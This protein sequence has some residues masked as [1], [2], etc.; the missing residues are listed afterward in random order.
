[1]TKIC[2]KCGEEKSLEDF[3]KKTNAPDGRTSQCKTCVAKYAKTHREANPEKVKVRNAKWREENPEY[4]TKWREENP[5]KVKATATARLRENPE[6]EKSRQAKWREENP[7]YFQNY[8]NTHKEE[9]A[10][11]TKKWGKENPGKRNAATAKRRAARLQATPKS[12]TDEQLA[13]MVSTFESCP[14]GSHVD[15]EI[16]FQNE[17]VCGLHVPWNLQIL[18][19]AANMKK[20]NRFDPEDHYWVKKEEVA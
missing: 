12:L 14:K 3:Y 20:G 18:T 5:E 4:M 17:L 2:T 13:Q 7:E 11:R 19:A 6:R 9:I 16:P 10:L 8:Q 15:H 1:M